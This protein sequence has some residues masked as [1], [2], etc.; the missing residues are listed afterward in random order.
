VSWALI[1]YCLAVGTART[2]AGSVAF[3]ERY[4]YTI[5][6]A[7]PGGR[8]CVS[9]NCL[10]PP[11]GTPHRYALTAS[12]I[13]RRGAT[14]IA[15]LHKPRK[16]VLLDE[17]IR[18]HRRVILGEVPLGRYPAGTSRIP[19]HLRLDRHLLA[20]GGYE[21]SLHSISVGVLSPAIPPREF[22][23]TVK[24]NRQVHVGRPTR[25]GGLR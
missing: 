5:P 20:P 12:G 6:S 21:V 14:V 8:T 18:R 23:L 10:P 1:N 16:L 9:L 22:T 13:E 4:L 11:P 25:S 15:V 3:A 17:E 2:A 24:A 7:G 19:W